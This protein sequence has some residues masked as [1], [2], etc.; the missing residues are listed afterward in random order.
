M[1]GEIARIQLERFG[2]T[3]QIDVAGLDFAAIAR[4]Y[5]LQGIRVETERNLEPSFKKAFASKQPVVIDVACGS[6]TA[7]PDFP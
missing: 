2:A 1:Y 4:S 3:S 5:G 6:D 7:F